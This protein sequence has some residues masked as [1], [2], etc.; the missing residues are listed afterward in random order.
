MTFSRSRARLHGLLAAATLVLLG[1]PW[2]VT[3]AGQRSTRV[4]PRAVSP[5]GPLLAGEQATIDL[6]ERARASVAYISTQTR[7]VDSW[8][9]NVFGV[10]RIL[11]TTAGSTAEAAGL[12]G[13]RPQS[14][15]TILQATSSL[16]WRHDRSTA[17]R[18]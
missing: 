7:V 10:P 18:V 17:W 15:G 12:R 6:F 16:R 2:L 8:T 13:V 9:R 14:D 11:R 3:A 5:R 4:T 1:T